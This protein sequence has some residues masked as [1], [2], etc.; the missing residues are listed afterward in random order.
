MQIFIFILILGLS[1]IL[2]ALDFQLEDGRILLYGDSCEEVFQMANA[3]QEWQYKSEKRK[4]QMSDCKFRKFVLE[5]GYHVDV[6]DIVPTW[7]KENYDKYPKNAGPNC[8]NSAL[9]ATQFLKYLRFTPPGEMSF[10]LNSPL[11]RPRQTKEQL[12]PGDIIAIRK[13]HTK[14]KFVEE[15]HGFIYIENG[16][17]F[18]K[19]GLS[20]ERSYG[21]FETEE[22]FDIY[23]VKEPACKRLFG[24]PSIYV[25]GAPQKKCKVYAQYFTC[26]PLEEYINKK[27]IKEVFRE[28][29]ELIDFYDCKVSSEALDGINTNIIYRLTLDTL[30][31]IYDLNTKDLERKDLTGSERFLIQSMQFKI[32]GIYQQ[33]NIILEEKD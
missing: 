29:S 25:D 12:Q 13:W 15:V 20:K 17:V 27:N 4:S 6:T 31:A 33:I 16:L 32:N 2:H 23:D 7:L 14:S 1:S 9:Y 30:K 22:V 21:L 5:W 26:K 8:W 10:Y 18:S 28:R 11:C 19:N 24:P 3:I